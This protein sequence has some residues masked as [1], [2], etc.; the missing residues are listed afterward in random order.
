MAL[1]LV[2][3]TDLLVCY[4]VMRRKVKGNFDGGAEK[5]YLIMGLDLN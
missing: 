1:C 5:A 2:K 3:H 4:G